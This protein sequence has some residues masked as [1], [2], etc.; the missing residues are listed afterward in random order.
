MRVG[1][2]KIEPL[3]CARRRPSE[4]FIIAVAVL[5]LLAFCVLFIAF[6][7]WVTRPPEHTRGYP[8]DW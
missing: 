1:S 8:H 3:Q 5:G 6:A 2:C 7:A 4:T